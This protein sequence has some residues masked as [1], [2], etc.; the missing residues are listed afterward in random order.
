MLAHINIKGPSRVSH[1]GVDLA[2]LDEVA[3]PA[4]ERAYRERELVVI[5]EIGKMELFSPRFREAVETIIQSGKRV[6][7]TIMLSPNPYA[8]SIKCH[9]QVHVITVT[10]NNHQQV[11]EELQDWLNIT[12]STDD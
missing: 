10:R 9:P 7:G 12:K 4:L 2:S 1:Y 6:L 3:V 8:D 11:L 5:D